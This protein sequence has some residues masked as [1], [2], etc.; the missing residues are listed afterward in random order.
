MRRPAE[1][2]IVE[3]QAR[4]LEESDRFLP[5]EIAQMRNNPVIERVNHEALADKSALDISFKE[6]VEQINQQIAVQQQQLDALKEQRKLLIKD[7]RADVADLAERED[8]PFV[9]VGTPAPVRILPD[10]VSPAP[11]SVPTPIG[12]GGISIG[13]GGAVSDHLATDFHA[14]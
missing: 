6:A 8:L 11:G 4:I 5:E 7:Y 14:H 3:R 2:R 13:G 10:V 1:N 12:G 9:P